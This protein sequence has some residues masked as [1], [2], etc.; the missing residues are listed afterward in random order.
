MNTTSQI[1]QDYD[2]EQAVLGGLLLAPRALDEWANHIPRNLFYHQTHA[3]LYSELL[4][5]W[6]TGKPVDQITLTQHLKARNQWDKIGGINTLKTL[7]GA[8]GSVAN[9]GQHVGV[10]QEKAAKRRVIEISTRLL[11]RAYGHEP[12]EDIVAFSETEILNARE[13][14]RAGHGEIVSLKDMTT[15]ILGDWEWRHT[16][17]DTWERDRLKTG[18][19]NLDA[20]L[21]LE[22]GRYTVIAARPGIGK[23]A[24]ATCIGLHNAQRGKGVGIISC[25]QSEMLLLKRMMAAYARFS[26]ANLEKGLGNEGDLSKVNQ[27][28]RDLRQWPYFVKSHSGPTIGEIRAT[29]RRMRSR[30]KIELGIVDYLQLVNGDR[31]RRFGN[32][33]SEVAH[34]SRELAA[35]S[36]E[37]GIPIIAMAQLNRAA[38]GKR[39]TLADLRESGSIEQDAS[40]VILLHRDRE[41]AEGQHPGKTLAIVAKNNEGA[42]GECDLIY[43]AKT[44]RFEQMAAQEAKATA[45][46]NRKDING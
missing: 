43:H 38:E 34:V 45:G 23:T 39:P 31:D 15:Q 41:P 40:R 13:K 9:L 29:L 30:H 6:R 46:S 10:L 42:T 18:F 32:R 33:E 1:P 35:A 8:V 2:A 21:T 28:V 14:V 5:L 17:R 27:A 36:Q 19:P 22:P 26:F 11:E 44:L 25:E 24:L 16:N 37:L 3:T 12:W 20:M 7:Y 4:D